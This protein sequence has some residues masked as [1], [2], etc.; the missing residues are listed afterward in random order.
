MYRFIETELVT[1]KN[2]LNHL[3]LLLRGARQVG[4]TYIVEKFGK[5]HF[6]SMITLNLEYQPEYQACFQ[7]LNPHQIIDAIALISGQPIIP[8][9]TLLFID[10]IQ[11]HAPAIQSLRYFKEKMPE[12]H[13]IGAGSL[14]EFVLNDADFRMPVGRVQFIYL[15]PLSFLEFLMALK[16]QQLVAY[17]NKVT[18]TDSIPLPVHTQLLY[19]VRQYMVLGGMPAVIQSFIDSGDTLACQRIQSSLLATYQ[20]DFGKYTSRENYK[21]LQKV[22]AKAP[23]LIG[24]QVKYVDI[25]PETRSRELKV[26]IDHLKCAGLIFLIYSTQ[27]NGL[28]LNVSMNEKRY[29]L[30]FLDVGLA[31]RACHID[32]NVLLKED[33]ML[34]NRGMLAEQYVGQELLCSSD[35]FEESELFFWHKEKLGSQAEVD[36]VITLGSHIVP[37]EVKAGKTGRLKSLQIFLQERQSPLG[38]RVSEL[39]LS[40]DGKILSIPFY[41]LSQ[42]ERLY[43][44]VLKQS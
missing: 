10:E 5:Q 25:D 36:Y 44:A 11:E 17:L 35:F 27:A 34:I 6:D 1:W 15:R 29:K 30:L 33:L 2:Q 9:Q 38:I 8:G 26:A 40:L 3:P 13:V 12:L 4:K 22:F 16:Q 21:Y 20:N 42:I 23:G 19:Y 14:L 37:L 39:P 7:S 43:A 31:K 41:L 24:T 32:I 28:P 18:L